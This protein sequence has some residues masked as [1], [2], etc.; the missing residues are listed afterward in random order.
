MRNG[1]DAGSFLVAETARG[2]A[3]APAA[4]QTGDFLGALRYAAGMA[5]P[6]SATARRGCAASRLRTSP[7]PHTGPLSCSQRRRWEQLTS[8]SSMALLP[9][10]QCRHRHAG[11]RERDPDRDRQAAGLRRRRASARRR[12]RTAASRTS[13]ATSLVGTCASDRRFKKNI[14]PF[15]RVLDQPHAPCSPSTTTGAPAEFPDRHFGDAQTYGLDRAGRR[16]GA[17]RAR[18][19]KWRTDTRRST[20]ASCRCSRIQAVKGAEGL[21]SDGIEADA[22]REI[23]ALKQRRRRDRAR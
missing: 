9:I 12:H 6:A 13:A 18:R 17:A 10:R 11:R 15:G 20:T 23:D 16:A 19:H 14:T 3:A 1:A 4:V 7:I 22:S 5:R 21:R 2:T 8:S